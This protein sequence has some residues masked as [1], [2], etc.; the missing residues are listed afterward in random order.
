MASI[1]IYKNN[2]Y[3]NSVYNTPIGKTQAKNSDDSTQTSPVQN[4]IKKPSFTAQQT[5][6]NLRTELTTNEEKEKYS[7][8][9]TA[10]DKHERKSLELLLKKGILLNTNS[11]DKSSTLDSLY[12]II[13]TQRA[14]GLD[15][16]VTLKETINTLANPFV[17]TQR[18][19]DTP[20]EYVKEILS[21]PHDAK[22]NE[23]TIDVKNSGACVAASI[24]F[25]LAKQM[26]AEFARFAE[27]LTS[28]KVAVDKT[29]QLK[30]LANNTLDSVWLLNAFEVPYEM[31]DFNKAKLKLAP[32]KNALIRAQIQNSNK[33]KLERS[34]VDVL[35][36]ST[37]M[38]VGSQQSYNSLT[39]I[40]EGKFNQ[41]DKG[42]IEFEKTFTESVV[43]DKNKISVTYQIV[44]EN[45]K[46][47]GYETDFQT[48]KKHLLDSLAMGENVIIGYTQVDDKNTII[49]GHEITIIGAR[50]DKNDKLIFICNDTDDDNPRP[51]EYPEDYIIPKIHHAGLPQKVVEKDVKFVDNWV[52]GINAYKNG[53]TSAQPKKLTTAA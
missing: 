22:V 23:N 40:R 49:N 17:I 20:K 25:N 36:Q 50:K 21:K 15:P 28:P 26:P 52:E 13:T 11:N 24:E 27:Q 39:D 4:P 6:L 35:M 43:E 37:F 31:D 29:I 32:D 38:N 45:A 46:L 53:K 30:N 44:D 14:D 2:I 10:L 34:L 48:V 9:V 16:K 42:L 47:T 3:S 18:F 12:K 19:G 1:G 5:P 8:L 51:I 41:N 33:D 7:K